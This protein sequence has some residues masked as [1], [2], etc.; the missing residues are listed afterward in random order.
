MRTGK[1]FHADW[2][3]IAERTSPFFTFVVQ[4]LNGGNLM[5]RAE[6]RVGIAIY[7]V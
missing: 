3:N 1:L 5:R 7:C 4:V 2:Y 6:W